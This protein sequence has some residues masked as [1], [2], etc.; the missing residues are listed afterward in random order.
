MKRKHHALFGLLVCPFI[1]IET[2]CACHVRTTAARVRF[3]PMTI[4]EQPLQVRF[5]KPVGAE[6]KRVLVLYA[7]GDG[8]WKALDRE[9]FSWISGLGYPVAGLSS[10]Q[11]LKNM[12]S[13]SDTTT[14]R[15]LARDYEHVIQ[16]AKE[17]LGLPADVPTLL[18]GLSRGAGLA[19]VAAGVGEIQSE[20][21]GV[22]A[23]A[24]TKEEEHVL[25][26]LRRR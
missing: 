15:R 26:R 11:Y 12:R 6:S 22:L 7:T 20:L 2:G 9:I 1:L 25:H 16:S 8:G 18:V 14:P 24:L 3:A 13:V 21:A 4:Y 19:V 10:R 17:T 5:A 23:I